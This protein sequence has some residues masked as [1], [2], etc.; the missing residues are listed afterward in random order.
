VVMVRWQMG[1][2]RRALIVSALRALAD[3]IERQR[4]AANPGPRRG[5]T[6]TG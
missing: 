2:R 4:A 6:R 1:P 5:S 3:H